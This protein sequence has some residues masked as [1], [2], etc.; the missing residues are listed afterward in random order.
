MAVQQLHLLR[1]GIGRARRSVSAFGVRCADPRGVDCKREI[2]C[3]VEWVGVGGRRIR[4][5]DVREVYERE[6][7]EG[8]HN[9]RHGG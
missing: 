6:G 4:D 3:G 2:T 5:G 7:K 8:G 9:Q 1:R